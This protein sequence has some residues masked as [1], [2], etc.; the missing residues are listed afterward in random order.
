[1]GRLPNEV[2]QIHMYPKQ[3]GHKLAT[4]D[5]KD[6]AHHMGSLILCSIC[7]YSFGL[8]QKLH[9]YSLHLF[10][11]QP[12]CILK[13]VRLL[14]T[15]TSTGFVSCLPSYSTAWRWD[16]HVCSASNKKK[17]QQK[18]CCL[19]WLI[20]HWITIA[21]VSYTSAIV[22]RCSASG[23]QSYVILCAL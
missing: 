16:I 22:A 15:W 2:I 5:A 19:P 23:S 20:Q 21:E 18:I 12:M 13:C 3:M 17:Q 8:W 9:D 7:F 11:N 14:L 4:T 10:H 6:W 1:M